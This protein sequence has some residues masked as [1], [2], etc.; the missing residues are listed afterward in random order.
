MGGA[1]SEQLGSQGSE[2]DIACS[3]IMSMGWSIRNHFPALFLLLMLFLL[4]SAF[5]P[6]FSFT[7]DW[8]SA[9]TGCSISLP[10]FLSSPPLVLLLPGEGEDGWMEGGK[11]GGG[12]ER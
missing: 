6:P 10:F 12:V 4:F 11:G 3:S 9:F 2:G 7:R 5:F 8:P 1:Y